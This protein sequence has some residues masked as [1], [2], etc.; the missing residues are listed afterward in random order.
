MV[1]L[2]T[3]TPPTPRDSSYLTPLAIL[4]K[5]PTLSASLRAGTYDA[6][7]NLL[8]TCSLPDLT[9]LLPNPSQEGEGL[10]GVA[11]EVWNAGRDPGNQ[12]GGVTGEGNSDDDDDDA[13]SSGGED[14]FYNDEIAPG[15]VGEEPQA[16][17]VESDSE[18]EEEEWSSSEDEDLQQLVQ[19]LQ[20]FVE[21]ASE[22]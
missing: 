1:P 9:S 14:V 7:A 20:N 18:E 22:F 10:G 5:Q 6:G 17:G 16:E 15:P 2:D 4:D 8:R 13:E 19:T 11:S 12:G 3:A 21:E